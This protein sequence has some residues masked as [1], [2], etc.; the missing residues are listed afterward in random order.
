[1]NTKQ[2]TGFS[3]IPGLSKT[4]VLTECAM[5]VALATVL[6]L[7][8]IAEMPAGGSVTA[9]AML[10]I[11]LLSYRHG[12]KVG[13]SSAFVFAALQALLGMKNFSYVSGWQSVLAVLFLDYLLAYVTV[14]LAGILKDRKNPAASM[15][16]GT[17]FVCFL[18]YLCATVSGAVIWVECAVALPNA[19][20]WTYS[21]AYNAAYMI[22]ETLVNAIAVFYV[23]SV[24]N[25]EN[26]EVRPLTKT[27]KKTGVPYLAIGSLLAVLALIFDVV[28]L[29]LHIQTEDGFAL[30][31]LREAPVSALV[32]VS[33]VGVAA[34]VFGFFLEKKAK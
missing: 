11:V 29:F 7:L 17:V 15:A 28:T 5:M 13:L 6:S 27:A 22:P 2:S 3:R 33:A 21:L 25:F 9:A 30:S 24:L 10:P 12:T 1:M 31:A 16:V 23:G 32:I 18:R 34:Y 8:K 4:R 26:A 19:A 20:A 14:G